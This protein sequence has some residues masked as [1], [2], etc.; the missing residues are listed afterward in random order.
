MQ[1]A[2]RPRAGPQGGR[3][4][5]SPAR[6]AILHLRDPG[7]NSGLPQTLRLRLEFAHE[8]QP[9]AS[10]SY[11]LAGC[12][13]SRPREG[14]GWRPPVHPHMRAHEATSKTS[15]ESAY[16]P[17]Q[18][19]HALCYR[20]HQRPPVLGRIRGDW[21]WRA[22]AETEAAV[23]RAVAPGEGH[24]GAGTP[25]QPRP[26]RRCPPNDAPSDKGILTQASSL[27]FRPLSP[28]PADAGVR[29]ALALQDER[30]RQ[31]A[32]APYLMP[33]PRRG[34]V[35]KSRYAQALRREVMKAAKDP[36][37]W[38]R[39]AHAVRCAWSFRMRGACAAAAPCTSHFALPPGAR[40]SDRSPAA[41]QIARADQRRAGPGEGPGGGA[42][43]PLLPLPRR[44][45]RHRRL[46][47]VRACW[48]LPAPPD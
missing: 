33:P 42:H 34:I 40:Q 28:G 47:E 7:C 10:P 43:P 15:R 36:G 29:R 12:N 30:A 6:L 13:K 31:A 27:G 23:G 44:A 48:G 41:P 4:A 45:A 1:A 2:S 3:R 18:S 24:S 11:A 16:A 21:S 8:L 20:R 32:L 39:N 9:A 37:R 25:H 19:P 14:G 22:R 35:G 38:A 26:R 5:T 17:R 46:P